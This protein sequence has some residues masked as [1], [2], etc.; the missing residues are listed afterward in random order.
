MLSP[1]PIPIVFNIGRCLLDEVVHRITLRI[2]AN[3][4][5]AAIVEV[6]KVSKKTIYKLWLNM[7]I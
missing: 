4:D 2:E 5:V 6:V 1:L 3:E 7:D